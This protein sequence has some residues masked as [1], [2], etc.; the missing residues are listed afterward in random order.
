MG[1]RAETLS[2]VV[3][4]GLALALS[5]IVLK[6]QSQ[7]RTR[8]PKPKLPQKRTLLDYFSVPTH[9]PAWG[10]AWPPELT[11]GHCTLLHP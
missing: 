8:S 3:L 2:Y 10:A 1:F 11:G 5:Q 7:F 6:G 4:A 9:R